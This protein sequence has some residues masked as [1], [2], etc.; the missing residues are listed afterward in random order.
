MPNLTCS[1]P[2][3]GRWALGRS[4]SVNQLVIDFVWAASKSNSFDTV[5]KVPQVSKKKKEKFLKINYVFLNLV[6]KYEN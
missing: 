6:V 4:I 3:D 1:K 5:Q 2:F